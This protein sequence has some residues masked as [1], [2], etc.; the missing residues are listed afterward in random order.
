MVNLAGWSRRG[1]KLFREF[2]LGSFVE[3]FAVMTKAA[4]LSERIGHHPDWSNSY[5]E[6]RVE[7]TTRD[8]GG[9]SELD[10]LWAS[11]LNKIMDHKTER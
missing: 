9:I 3:A 8:C 2:R 7:L 4:L 10:F 1:H 6:L 11:E 5:G